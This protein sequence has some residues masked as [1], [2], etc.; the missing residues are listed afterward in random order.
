MSGG[1]SITFYR[2]N[3]A[4]FK[5]LFFTILSRFVYKRNWIYYY[6]FSLHV[7][8]ISSE[9]KHRGEFCIFLRSRISMRFFLPQIKRFWNTQ[10]LYASLYFCSIMLTWKFRPMPFT[11]KMNFLGSFMCYNFIQM[12]DVSAR[13]CEYREKGIIRKT[14]TGLEIDF[15]LL[16]NV[17]P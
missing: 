16:A 6:L 14:R 11:W 8:V 1:K 10:F 5:T 9:N 3:C 4:T 12:G 13:A 7:N 2:C 15:F 17:F